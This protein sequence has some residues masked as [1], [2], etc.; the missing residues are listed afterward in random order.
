MFDLTSL[1]D[2]SGA[3][4]I[5]VAVLLVCILL[6]LRYGRL[7]HS[8]P[9]TI[10]LFFHV[11]CFTMRLIG[12]QSGSPTLFQDSGSFET[13]QHFEIVRASL[14]A[15]AVLLVMTLAWLWASARDLK[16]EKKLREGRDR[17]YSRSLSY[18]RSVPL[19]VFPIGL[20]GLWAY[21]YLPGIGGGR[22]D[23]GEWQTSSWLFITQTW[24]GLALL[25]LIYRYG[26]KWQLTLPMALYLLLMALQGYHRFRVIIPII[27]LVQ[28]YLDRRKLRWPPIYA[29][30]L[31]IVFAAIFFPLKA[32]GTLT[33][34]GRPITEIV[35][36][37]KES[38]GSALVNDHP[39][40]TF[41]DQFGSALTL[42]DRSEKFYYGS[43]YLAL[44]LNPI[45]R[46][47]WKDKPGLNDYER[48]FSTEARPMFEIGQTIT[49]LGESYANFGV[50]GLILIPFLLAYWLARI[51][52][53]AYR[54]GYLTVHRFAY[55]LIACNL[56]QV[57]RDGLVSMVLFTFVNMMPL[58]VIVILHYILPKRKKGLTYA[59]L[60]YPQTIR[61]AT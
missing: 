31:L 46:Q 51:Y 38:I 5:D 26:F 58:A 50:W 34:Q 18:M 45:P 35:E 4:L 41:L 33:Q 6:L 48:D 16:Q 12:L 11:Y 2:I 3:L 60:A 21:A 7:S 47:L 9:G 20:L 44:A 19:I 56:I 17:E 40:E 49:F 61:S 14:W 36:F 54:R 55:L 24:A 32:I 43:T 39:D 52:F 25:A 57:Y 13:V 30:P 29:F 37:S 42:I 59:P 1:V 53:R 15:D 27:L 28:I 22:V 8:H 10:Y 23:L